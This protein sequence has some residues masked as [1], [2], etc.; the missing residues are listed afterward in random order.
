MLRLEYF[1]KADDF[2]WTTDYPKR[3]YGGVVSEVRFSST[4]GDSAVFKKYRKKSVC[5]PMMLWV[6]GC[7]MTGVSVSDADKANGSPKQG[8]MI[9]MN[10]DNQNDKWLVNAKWFADNYDTTPVE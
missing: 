9:A 2:Y 10:A 1:D 6:P 5:V 4:S 8:D 3:Y 7:D